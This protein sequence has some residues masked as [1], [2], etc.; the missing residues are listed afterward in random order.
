[1]K[2]KLV[3]V[4]I[5][6]FN[7][8]RYLDK[9]LSSL[10][11]QSYSDFECIMIDDGSTD[12]GGVVCDEW[13]KKDKRFLV[14]HQQ[15]QGVSKARNKGIEVSSGK[16]ITFIDSDDWVEKDYLEKLIEFGK[17]S[18]YCVGG[19]KLLNLNNETCFLPPLIKPQSI[20]DLDK[21]VISELIDKYLIFG[22]CH[23]LYKR[24]II[25]NNKISFPEE[26]NYGEDLMFNID[27]LKHCTLI[28]SVPE[29]LYYYN[30]HSD[31]LSTSSNS[32]DWEVNLKQWRYVASFLIEMGLFMDRAK[33]SMYRR[34]VGLIYDS[35]FGS[36]KT[37]SK[38]YKEIKEIL[39]IPETRDREFKICV[40]N[41]PCSGWIKFCINYR[42]SRFITWAVNRKS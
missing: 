12:G 29:A 39:N 14:V 17:A 8:V 38:N 36:R 5:P 13:V 2:E 22:P 16:W 24:D 21:N 19:Y 42:M 3:S 11:D 35:I 30:K 31:S 4:I 33:R 40:D 1:M 32:M 25:V 7:S 10:S 34:L 23:K 9:V 28:A 37:N 26:L 20:R 15:N 41:F 6:V 27:Y 18:D